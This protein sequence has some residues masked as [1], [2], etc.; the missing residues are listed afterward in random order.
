MRASAI[1]VL[2]SALGLPAWQVRWDA[3]VGLDMNLGA[4]RM[5]LRQPRQSAA[6]S[7]RVRAAF[8][9]RAVYLRGTHWLVAYPGRWRVDLADGLA[10][11]DT[12]SAKRLDMAVARL[13]GE[14][15]DGLAIN[16]GTG[17]TE[18]F[19]DLGG[20]ISVRWPR[21]RTPEPAAELWS[22]H[23]RSRFVA[24]FAGGQYDTGPLN[25]ATS[26]P[27]PVG[28]SDWLVVARSAKR[29]HGILEK[30]RTAAA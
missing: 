15:L 4:P 3:Q 16:P 24:V 22:M 23:S 7:A 27:R 2:R 19:F 30:L 8:A 9:R 18:F 11:R 26:S 14:L 29:E 12:H 6:R 17:Q 21:G 20:R 5:E 13:G 1:R 10:V 25:Q 28:T